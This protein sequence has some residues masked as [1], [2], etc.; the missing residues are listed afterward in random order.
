MRTAIKT[1]LLVTLMFGTLLG[2]AN[3]DTKS[4]NTV[5]VK[6]VKVEYKAVKKGQALTIKNENGLTIYK[7][8]IKASGNFSKTFD[9]TNLNDGLFT[10]ELE[11]DFEIEVQK[12]EV[13]DGF[14]TF[15]KEENE[16]IFK[17]VIRTN[18]DLILISKITFNEK[19]LNVTLY[20]NNKVIASEDIEGKDV[21]N[22][23]YKLSNKEKGAYKV[24]VYSDDRMYT[25]D[26]K[27]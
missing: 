10:T 8:F 19:P 4:T 27:I 5:A 18:G 20:Y 9:L 6:R 12:I 2:Y 7:Q 24:V 15:L 17:P 22:R 3:E 25:K 14:V 1:I 13:K 21:L 26:F 16:T 11:K 23:I